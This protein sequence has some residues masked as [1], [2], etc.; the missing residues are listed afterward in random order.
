MIGNFVLL[1]SPGAGKGTI[2]QALCEQYGLTHVSS[3]DLLRKEVRKGSLIGRKISTTLDRGEQ[4]SDETI[5]ELV[6]STLK[7]LTLEKQG[8]IL[9]GY[10][11]TAS[12]RDSLQRFAEEN[13]IE[14][15]YI[16]VTVNPETAL[17]R[18]VNRISCSDCLK[19]FTKSECSSERCS[20]CDGEL[21]SRNSDAESPARSRLE[22]FEKTTKPLMTEVAQD[23]GTIEVNGNLSKESVLESLHLKL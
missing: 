21:V 1:G 2:C 4:V 22:Q 12:Q 9:D 6:T 3:G 8:F 17:Q 5:T 20:A 16:C 13:D 10:P 19:I 7:R 14:F 18:M 11:Q 23:P 15:T